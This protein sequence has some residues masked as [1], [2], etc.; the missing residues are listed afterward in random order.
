M[1]VLRRLILINVLPLDR[2]A[3]RVQRRKHLRILVCETYIRVVFAQA[4]D[5]GQSQLILRQGVL[6]M[7]GSRSGLF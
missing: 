2:L 6:L 3:T 7:T 1:L 4:L 5:S